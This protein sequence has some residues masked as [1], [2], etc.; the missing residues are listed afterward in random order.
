MKVL[1][2]YDLSPEP[3]PRKEG[4]EDIAED[5]RIFFKSPHRI[6]IPRLPKRDITMQPVTLRNGFI[7]VVDSCSQK[8]IKE[9]G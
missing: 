9:V 4:T 6:S 1:L 8:E 3:V 5:L 2:S 7:P